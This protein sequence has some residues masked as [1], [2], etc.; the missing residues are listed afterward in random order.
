MESSCNVT[1][2]HGRG[3]N[4]GESDIYKHQ[5]IG[6]ESERCGLFQFHTFI[7]WEGDVLACCH[8]L[9]GA[10]SI[11]NLVND[12]VT[13]IAERKREVLKNSMPFTVCQ[14]CD[15]PLRR[16]PPTQDTIPKNRKERTRFFRSIR[17]RENTST[18][19]PL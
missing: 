16:C 15:E 2:C 18:I 17:V 5:S 6:L 12:D 10:T 11:G 3:G 1:A 8:D 14:Q 4:L 13:I 7:T 9:D 19:K